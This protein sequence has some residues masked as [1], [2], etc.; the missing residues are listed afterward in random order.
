M[1]TEPRFITIKNRLFLFEAT[2]QLGK[3][4]DLSGPYQC[5]G[6]EGA[7][8]Q[9]FVQHMTQLMVTALHKAEPIKMEDLSEKLQIE[10]RAALGEDN[11]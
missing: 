1:L 8:A 4:I 5:I 9:D 2:M 10:I 3:V 11:A 6:S 7:S